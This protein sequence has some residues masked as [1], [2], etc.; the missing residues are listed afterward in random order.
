MV[1]QLVINS[2]TLF[3]WYEW[4]S[5]AVLR[6]SVANESLLTAKL[7]VVKGQNGREEAFAGRYESLCSHKAAMATSASVLST[8]QCSA[9]L[10]TR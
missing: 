4:A 3:L 1:L 9:C 10:P 7:E 8:A 5:G 2:G 6:W